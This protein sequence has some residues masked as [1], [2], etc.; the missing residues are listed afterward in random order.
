MIYM[1]TVDYYIP[2]YNYY[3][4]TNNGVFKCYSDDYK[5]LVDIN[6][7]LQLD[8]LS[9][10]SCGVHGQEKGDIKWDLSRKYGY[11]FLIDVYLSNQCELEESIF[12]SDLEDGKLFGFYKKMTQKPHFDCSIQKVDIVDKKIN[13]VYYN[14][15]I[16]LDY[17]EFLKIVND[18]RCVTETI[19]DYIEY[20]EYLEFN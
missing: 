19:R 20:N 16:E 9:K 17:E 13:I 14:E 2:Y 6:S 4:Y 3:D 1:L 11:E 5:K 8:F 12:L 7:Y 18:P 10:L 15:D